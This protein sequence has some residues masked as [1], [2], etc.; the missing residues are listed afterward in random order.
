MLVPVNRELWSLSTWKPSLCY[1]MMKP[2]IDLQHVRDIITYL[3]AGDGSAYFPGCC[4]I[5]EIIDSTYFVPSE[6]FISNSVEV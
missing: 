5:K 4:R 3:S 2:G 6:F 1:I